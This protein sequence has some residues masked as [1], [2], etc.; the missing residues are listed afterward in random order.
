M[1]RG[2]PGFE[3]DSAL[4]TNVFRHRWSTS[5][6]CASRPPRRELRPARCRAPVVHDLS[7]AGHFDHVAADALGRP[8][9]RAR[10][11]S[12]AR[13]PTGHARRRVPGRGT[14]QDPARGPQRRA[15]A[16][17]SRTTPTTWTADATPLWLIL[18]GV[19]RHRPGRLRSGALDKVAAA[20]GWIDRYGDRDGD[21]YVEYQTRSREGLGNQCQRPGRRPPADGTIPHLPIATAEIQ[22]TSTTPSCASPSC[23]S[24]RRDGESPSGWSARPRSCTRVSTRDF[25]SDARG[26]YYALLDGDKRPID[27]LTS[28]IG[29]LLSSGSSPRARLVVAGQLMSDAMFSAGACAPCRPT[30]VATT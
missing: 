3:S 25:W 9:A 22:A 16:A 8:E 6:R 11:A 21:G 28:N 15:D 4:L 17:V 14:R 20:L 18:P 30:I 19:L 5:R 29:H 2:I 12:S 7:R 24:L 26:G 13:R 27:S 1:A 10:S 23:A